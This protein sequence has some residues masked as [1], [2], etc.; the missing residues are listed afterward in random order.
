MKR[1]YLTDYIYYD[2]LEK[3]VIIG[4]LRQV[5][6]TTLAKYMGE[7][8]FKSYC[9]MNRDYRED[10]KNSKGQSNQHRQIS[11]RAYIK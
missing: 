3:M 11:V 6:K 9:Y 2:L 7:S 10:R 1:R 5:G 8:Y 4:G